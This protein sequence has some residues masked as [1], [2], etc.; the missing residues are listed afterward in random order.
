MSERKTYTNESVHNLIK[1]LDKRQVRIKALKMLLRD[2]DRNCRGC[3]Y[4]CFTDETTCSIIN[5]IDELL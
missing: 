3:M 2:M 1:L 5:R 4:P